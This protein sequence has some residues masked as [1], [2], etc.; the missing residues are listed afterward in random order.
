MQDLLALAPTRRQKKI[1]IPKK[2]A[3]SSQ[4][5]VSDHLFSFDTSLVLSVGY[6]KTIDDAELNTVLF[7]KK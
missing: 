2:I 4:H 7:I 1:A 5:E 6:Y 3:E